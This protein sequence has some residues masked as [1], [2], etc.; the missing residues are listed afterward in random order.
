MPEGRLQSHRIQR[1]FRARLRDVTV[2][3]VAMGETS[4]ELVSAESSFTLEGPGF[5]WGFS[6][7]RPIR[8]ETETVSVEI[9]DHVMLARAGA[10]A[11]ALVLAM[12]RLIS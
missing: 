4:V 9:R 7:R 3:S 1:V 5:G 12:R 2:D 10:L 11:I 8:V 6:Y